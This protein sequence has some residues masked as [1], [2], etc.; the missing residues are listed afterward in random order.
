[1]ARQW[2]DLRRAF[3][4]EFARYFRKVREHVPAIERVM[5]E[6]EAWLEA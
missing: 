6:E 3:V 2:H 5:R 4:P 1:V